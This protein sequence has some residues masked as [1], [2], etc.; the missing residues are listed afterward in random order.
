MPPATLT[1]V[2][3]LRYNQFGA[4]VGGPIWKNRT[5]FLGSTQILRTA[6]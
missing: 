3:S 2:S 4:T 6:R 5:F 1:R